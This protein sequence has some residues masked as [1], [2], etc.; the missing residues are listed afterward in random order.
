LR[1]LRLE[2]VRSLQETLKIGLGLLGI[3]APEVM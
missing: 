2:L 1:E 3:P